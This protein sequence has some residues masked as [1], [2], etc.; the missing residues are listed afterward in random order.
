MWPDIQ[1]VFLYISSLLS[2]QKAPT[3]GWSSP[4]SCFYLLVPYVLDLPFVLANNRSKLASYKIKKLQPFNISSSFFSLILLNLLPNVKSHSLQIVFYEFF[5]G[6]AQG[7]NFALWVSKQD[8]S[9]IKA[10]MAADTLVWLTLWEMVTHPVKTRHSKVQMRMNTWLN[11]AEW[12]LWMAR[13]KSFWTEEEETTRTGRFHQ[14]I[15]SFNIQELQL[16]HLYVLNKNCI[17]WNTA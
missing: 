2:L 17:C 3:S 15:H 6:N 16:Q 5:S 14:Y 13:W 7:P 12:V 4:R 8:D 1:L 9:T 10:C 11:M